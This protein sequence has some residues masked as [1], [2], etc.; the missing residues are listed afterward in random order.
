MQMTPYLFFRG[1]CRAAFNRYAEILDLP[2]PQIMDFSQLPEAERENMP[3]A[4]EDAVMHAMLMLPSGALMGSDDIGPEFQPMAGCSVNLM[5][6]TAQEANRVFDA[7]AEG[8]EIRM[9]LA[10]T[11]WTPAFGT[12]TDAFGIRWMVMAEG[13]Q[14]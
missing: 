4:A 11:F 9:P 13:P 2:A 5:V 10:E 3:G 12:L 1:N 8:G 14:G 6:A 7:L